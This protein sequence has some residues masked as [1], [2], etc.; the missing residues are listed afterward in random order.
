MAEPHYDLVIT[1]YVA[2]S[3]IEEVV[4]QL[5]VVLNSKNPHLEHSLSDALLFENGNSPSVE[6]ITEHE[7]KAYQQQFLTLGV[8]T[9]I[10]PTLQLIAPETPA[11]TTNTT[12]HYACPACGHQQPKTQADQDEHIACEAC[13]VIG[14]RYLKLKQKEKALEEEKRKNKAAQARQVKDQLQRART[15]LE[16]KMRQEAQQELGL[17][18]DK[19]LIQRFGFIGLI[20]VGIAVA[21][22]IGFMLHNTKDTPAET[23]QSLAAIGA[24][25]NTGSS[26]NTLPTDT[27]PQE[28][29][30]T[31]SGDSAPT[32][33]KHTALKL[34][35]KDA[36]YAAY[37]NRQQ[38]HAPQTAGA[39]NA[40]Q[41]QDLRQAID[42]QIQ[43]FRQQHTQRFISTN[44][45]HQKHKEKIQRLLNLGRLDL[46]T[47]FVQ[48]LDD[49]YEASILL[50]DVLKKQ[51]AQGASSNIPSILD[52]FNE[53]EGQTAQQR[54]LLAS[55]LC[56]AHTLTGN[57]HMAHTLLTQSQ[58]MASTPSSPLDKIKNLTFLAKEQNQ[59]GN[60]DF[61]ETLIRAA[62]PYAQKI[63]KAE[64]LERGMAFAYL[65]H[66]HAQLK[67]LNTANQLL[68]HVKD[69]T[70][71]TNLSAY[72]SE[73]Q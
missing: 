36:V 2:D 25:G 69:E 23:A 38:R 7:A 41:S 39:G 42:K 1:Q 8:K 66:G 16:E 73:I 15:E 26:I 60:R 11:D 63:D 44:E 31:I 3:P 4:A 17:D 28:Q 45:T 5:M 22:N 43:Q 48:E 46:V 6:N 29:T 33:E 18:N 20:V 19:S 32:T 40:S 72:F 35:L 47:V 62:T 68:Q 71:R 54:A 55:S 14:Q 30:D 56:A 59:L 13:G 12:E 61:A 53:L 49:P 51:L 24:S 27:A 52:T 9:E 64:T 58:D 70:A 50:L 37:Q 65:A 10:R 21:A 57:E 34:Q 67:Q